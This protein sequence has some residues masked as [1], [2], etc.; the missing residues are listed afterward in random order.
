LLGFILCSGLSVAAET[1]S[2]DAL[3]PALA[4]FKLGNYTAAAENWLAVATDIQKR[5]SRHDIKALRKAGL[6]SV[7][8]TIAFS[9]ARDA[10]SYES[11]AQAIQYYLQGQTRWE[12]ERNKLRSQLKDITYALKVAPVSL[13]KLP[14]SGDELLLLEFEQTLALTEFTGPRPGLY[15]EKAAEEKP[16]ITI[17]HDYYARPLKVIEEE[18]RGGQSRSKYSMGNAEMVVRSGRASVIPSGVGSRL[19][20]LMV[21]PPSENHEPGDKRD[22]EGPV[23]DVAGASGEKNTI[24]QTATIDRAMLLQAPVSYSA[25]VSEL[26]VSKI[27]IRGAVGNPDSKMAQYKEIARRAWRYFETNEQSNTGLFNGS[28]GYFNATVWD[29]ASGLAALIAAEQL[30]LI[31]QKRFAR[32]VTQQLQTLNQIPLYN[33]VLPNREYNIQSGKMMDLRNRPSNKGSGWS[34]VDIGRFLIWLHLLKEWYP[35]FA[36]QADKVVARWDLSLAVNAGELQGALFDGVQERRF[37]EGRLGYEHYAAIGFLLWGV[38]V[39][40]AMDLD[41]VAFIDLYGV[42]VPYDK[43]DHSYL[44]TDPFVLLALEAG[45]IDD[46][47]RQLIQSVF[48]VQKQRWEK[49]YILT[50]RGESRLAQEPWFVYNTIYANKKPW[51][52]VS[53][54]GRSYPDFSGESTMIAFAWSAL[55][56]G[57]DYIDQLIG[58]VIDEF[59]PKFGYYSGF[60]QSGALNPSLEINTNALIL[61]TLLY[62]KRNKTSFITVTASTP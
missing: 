3:R 51:N 60:F 26:P 28:N 20:V 52:T 46:K 62:I 19:S 15:K 54:N 22:S 41:N 13:G 2:Y 61:E 50:A 12:E 30:G 7:A 49:E 45:G 44:T 55:L 59:H 23:P 47:F 17:T 9:K 24:T 16:E 57:D 21:E 33:D 48:E 37:Q 58:H 5:N 53:H 18:Q 29:M 35:E 8:A 32:L 6:A 14:V 25:H 4:L 56:P 31:E 39:R 36:P 38:D 40:F 27:P 42:Q 34:A 11:W 10:R 43:R 1:D